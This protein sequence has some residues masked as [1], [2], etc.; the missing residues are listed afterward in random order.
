MNL[1][2]V[3]ILLG[4][5]GSAAWGFM[6]GVIHQAIGLAL[7]YISIVLATIFYLTVTP[8]MSRIVRMEWQAAAAVS[9]L[10]LAVI[11]LNVLAISLRN[12]RAHE[13]KTLRLV[14]QLGG[15]TF[16]FIIAGIWIAL[17]IA[18]FYFAV[19]TPLAIRD[20]ERPLL[21]SLNAET[22][23]VMILRG[24]NRSPLVGAFEGLLPYILN[25]VAPFATTDN[26]LKIFVVR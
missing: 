8:W 24:L 20:P 7:F 26:I 4:L 11:I 9:F 6:K 18:L 12:V 3:L 14:N 15:M 21:L 19:S 22:F 1:F 25:S 23:R 13:F 10:L 17:L 2:D 16:G 5:T